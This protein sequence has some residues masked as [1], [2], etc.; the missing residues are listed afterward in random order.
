MVIVGFSVWTYV[1]LGFSY[2]VFAYSLETV[3]YS[4]MYILLSGEP[5][6]LWYVSENS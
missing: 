5:A 3:I 1:D 4:V 2:G 6:K